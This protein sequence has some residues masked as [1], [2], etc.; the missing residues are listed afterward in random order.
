MLDLRGGLHARVPPNS[1]VLEILAQ[2]TFILD[3]HEAMES[4]F[5]RICLPRIG[6]MKMV[7]FHIYIVIL[8]R[9]V[10][11]RFDMR[12]EIHFSNFSLETFE[13]K[14]KEQNYSIIRINHSN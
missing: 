6:N 13:T 5:I 7:F 3:I 8:N 1:H 12:S 10:F 9:M 4:C 14:Y 11:T 2:Q